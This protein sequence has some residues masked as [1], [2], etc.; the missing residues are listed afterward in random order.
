MTGKTSYVQ[1]GTPVVR[2]SLRSLAGSV[3]ET[4]CLFTLLAMML[5]SSKDE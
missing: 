5:A 1:E 3:T 2:H 4:F